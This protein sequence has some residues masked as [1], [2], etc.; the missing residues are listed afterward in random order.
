M[1]VITVT[2]ANA[3][4]AMTGTQTFAGYDAL[5]VSSD[6]NCGT[7]SP[8]FSTIQAAV[9]AANEGDTI[10]VAQGTYTSNDLQVAYISIG[11]TLTGGYTVT[12][13]SNPYPGFQTIL[14]NRVYIDGR[15]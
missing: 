11:I 1:Q 6:G 10:K 4:G 3:W 2:A 13:W 12:D 8:C 7:A 15:R 14:R 9:D 5:Y